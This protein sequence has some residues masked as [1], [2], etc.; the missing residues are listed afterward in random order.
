MRPVASWNG[1]GVDM[2]LALQEIGGADP[3]YCAVF[4]QERG[5]GRILGAA[6]VNMQGPSE[7]G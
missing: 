2:V 5:Q 6:V 4:V 7:G 1:E 3:A